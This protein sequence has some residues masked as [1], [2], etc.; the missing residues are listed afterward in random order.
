MKISMRMNCF[1]VRGSDSPTTTLDVLLVW[2]RL[3]H[4][5]T[6]VPGEG[7]FNDGGTLAISG[8]RVNINSASF[9]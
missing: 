9:F 4:I 2:D 3:V 7:I 8:A 1:E 5:V 6:F